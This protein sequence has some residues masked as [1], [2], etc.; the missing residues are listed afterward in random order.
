MS[1]VITTTDDLGGLFMHMV[2]MVPWKLTAFVTCLF[3][4]L[5]TS[6]F[7]DKVLGSWPGATDGRYPS[8]R[9]LLIQAALLTLG[10][11]IMSVCIG[12]GLL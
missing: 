10:M 11:I 6:T 1:D 5:N 7:V 3:I 12:G 8:E 2:H 9:G 4:I